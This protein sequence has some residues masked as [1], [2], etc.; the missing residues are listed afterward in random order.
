[1]KRKILLVVTTLTALVVQ[2]FAQAPTEM[3]YQAIVRDAAGN[4]LPGNTNV[5]VRFQIHD[6]TAAG[7]VVFQETNTAV[8]NQ[9]GLI[10]QVIG[11]TGNLAAV[12]WGGGPKYL[13]IEI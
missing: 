12:N 5:T 11:G 13:Q 1:M 6:Q 10:N 7:T 9:F 8:T 2:L 4:P 3:N